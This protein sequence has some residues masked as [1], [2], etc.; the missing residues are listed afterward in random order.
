[1]ALVQAIYSGSGV[2]NGDVLHAGWLK[3]VPLVTNVGANSKVKASVAVK[4]APGKTPSTR[5]SWVVVTS[6][7]MWSEYACEDLAT[8]LGS[9]S[10][11]TASHKILNEV[12]VFSL[13]SSK[14]NKQVELYF[15]AA[16]NIEASVW[17]KQIKLA[18]AAH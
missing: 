17:L 7:A 10:L 3:R 16:D 14:Y 11:Q 4:T 12:L 6:D 1:M 8:R 13:F 9:I 18:M 2:A 5:W 15:K